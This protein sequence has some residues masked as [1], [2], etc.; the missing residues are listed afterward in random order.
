MWKVSDII[1]INT[2]RFYNY[3]Y[4]YLLIGRSLYPIYYKDYFSSCMKGGTYR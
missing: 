2:D 4:L 1:N 3:L